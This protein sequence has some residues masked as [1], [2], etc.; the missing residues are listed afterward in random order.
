MAYSTI[1]ALPSSS[2]LNFSTLMK[3][4]ASIFVE[5]P[6]APLDTVQHRTWSALQADKRLPT[7][8]TFFSGSDLLRIFAQPV[9]ASVLRDSHYYP[10]LIRSAPILVWL[11]S[12]LLELVTNF[13]P[14]PEDPL[15][16]SSP[17]RPAHFAAAPLLC[18]ERWTACPT[19]PSSSVANGGRLSSSRQGTSASG[20]PPPADN[21]LNSSTSAM[22]V[23]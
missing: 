5:L 14:T 9:R 20:C 21:V 13:F 10:F 8:N 22:S 15:P 23:P 1:I 7:R 18:Q 4:S 3:S 2:L 11:E 16:S 12:A 17:P 6:Y 19:P